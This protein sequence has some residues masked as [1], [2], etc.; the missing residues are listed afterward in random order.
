MEPGLYDVQVD[1][2]EFETVA[3]YDGVDFR[4]LG[5]AGAWPS[6]HVAVVRAFS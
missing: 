4:V 1:G 2:L 5:I 3:E 6:R